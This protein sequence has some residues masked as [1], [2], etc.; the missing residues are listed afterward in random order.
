[1]V[2]LDEEPK[3]G[4]NFQNF[5]VFLLLVIPSVVVLAQFGSDKEPTTLET[6]P[7]DY[8]TP[9]DPV[10]DT[11]PPVVDSI[12]KV[13]EESV[14]VAEEFPDTEKLF[15]I[16]NN[17]WRCGSGDYVTKTV[18][19]RINGT[20][21]LAAAE[22]NHCCA[23]H[24]DC[25]DGQRGQKHCDK[26]FCECLEY[27]VATDPNAANCGNLTK[28]V[29]PLLSTYGR[30]AYDDSR[31]AKNSSVTEATVAAES[32][33]VPTQIPHLSEPYVGIYASCDEQHATFASCALNNDLCYR[34]PHAEPKEQCTV[35][36]IRCLDDTR[37]NRKPSKTCDLAIDEYL[38]K[39]I[40]FGGGSEDT[41]EM[42]TLQD[43]DKKKEIQMN[44]LMMQEILTNKTL[45]RNIYLQIV[46]H[47]SSLGWLSCLTFLFCVFSCCGI[48]IYAFSR[49]GEEEED[50]RRHDEV[51]NVHVTSSASEAPSSSTMSSMKSSS[52][53]TRK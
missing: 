1:M 38:W 14:V 6:V 23:V 24:D 5:S 4:L 30:F 22:F 31:N 47:S 18:I 16:P 13:E 33:K 34:T 41:K 8:S 19:S 37:F 20:C 17:L 48:L 43:E 53:S 9:E 10:D 46:R 40:R 39:L 51:I 29:C 25:Y 26:Q 12:P 11:E 52:S 3:Q 50:I 7:V 27:H 32:L 35:H 2:S 21:P 36:L 44:V 42:E 49:C 15:G 45:V 28:M